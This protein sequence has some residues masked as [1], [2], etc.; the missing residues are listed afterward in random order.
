LKPAR[1]LEITDDGLWCRDRSAGR[2]S[3]G[4]EWIV[5]WEHDTPSLV[6]E[7][8]SIETC[9]A[10]ALACFVQVNL[11]RRKMGMPKLL[12][13]QIRRIEALGKEHRLMRD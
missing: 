4:C 9:A 12:F 7:K 2:L 5:S 11:R 10:A 1:R 6:Y 8:T 3:F 13:G